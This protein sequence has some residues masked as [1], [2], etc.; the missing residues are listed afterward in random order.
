M[1]DPAL[2]ATAS[3][4]MRIPCSEP[5][6]RMTLSRNSFLPPETRR[7]K[8]SLSSAT[9]CLPFLASNPWQNSWPKRAS[10]SSTPAIAERGRAVGTFWQDHHTRT[11]WTFWMSCQPTLRKSPLGSVS[12]LPQIKYLS[13]EGASEA[14]QRSCRH[15]IPEPHDVLLTV[16][17]WIG[18]FWDGRSEPK[19][20]ARIT[21]SISAKRSAMRI[22]SRMRT[23]RSF[24]AAPFTIR[25][26]IEAKS[27]L[28]APDVPC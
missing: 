4:I 2:P 14:Q 8:G 1:P 22:G 23:G 7:G 5:D 18:R 12:G 20:H 9:G 6:L 25:G 3:A 15:W 11:F 16:R 19:H 10:G 24:A 17:S 21:L 28:E 27:M 26:I 13:S